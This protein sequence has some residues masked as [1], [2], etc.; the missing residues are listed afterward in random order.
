[1]HE[2]TFADELVALRHAADQRDPHMQ[3]HWLERLLARLEPTA[4]LAVPLERLY[5][6]LPVF[7]RSYPEERWVRRLLTGLVNLGHAPEAGITREALDQPFPAPGARNFLKGLHDLSEAFDTG[8]APEIRLGLAVSATVNAV[9]A[10]V[11]AFYYDAHPE[12][13]AR[14][15]RGVPDESAAFIDLQAQTL[16]YA[17]W[18]D[19]ETALIDSDAW[20]LVADSIETQARRSGGVPL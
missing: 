15:T 11:V 5:A 18:T 10:E 17:F 2:M 1:M 8:Y 7:E 19:P 4:A 20:H 3:Q 6:F 16:A 12:A 13:W 9:M 14:V